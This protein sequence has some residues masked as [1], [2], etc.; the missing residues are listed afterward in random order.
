MQ[1]NGGTMPRVCSNSV[2]SVWKTSKTH[3]KCCGSL[4]SVVMML[5]FPLLK[6]FVPVLCPLVL[7]IMIFSLPTLTLVH[8]P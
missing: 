8:Q 2:L 7:Y 6:W 3:I 1:E 5:L 4:F